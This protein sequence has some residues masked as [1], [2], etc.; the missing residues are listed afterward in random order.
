MERITSEGWMHSMRVFK[1]GFA[2]VLIFVILLTLLYPALQRVMAAEFILEPSKLSGG[3]Y[4]NSDALAAMLDQVFAGDIDIYS[5]NRYTQEVTM[6]VGVYM[7]NNAL[8]YVKSQTTGNP[9]S[10]W[11]CYIYGNAV[12]NKL[13]REWVGHAT[14]FMHSRVV[15]SGGSNTLSYEMM[16][17]AGVL[18]GAYLRTTGNS[19]GSY[20]GSVGHSM[21][22]LAYDPDNITYLEGNGDGNGLVRVAIRSWEDFNQ[23]QL[24]G[25]GRYIAHMVQPADEF[26]QQ[27]Y[28]S[29]P[30]DGYEG[31]G[32]CIDCGSV[33]DWQSTEDPWAKGI[34]RLTEKVTPRSDAPY[35][36]ATAADVILTKGQT[37]QTTGQYRNAFDQIWYRAQDDAGNTFYVNG[38][39]L[40][41]VEYPSLEVSC[42]DFSPEDGAQLEQK[43]Y[44]VKGT[45]TANFPLKSVSGYLDGQLYAT[46]TATDE[47]T[48]VVDLRKTDLNHNLSFSKLA[49]GK[50][51]VKV[52]VR[53]FVHGWDMTVHESAF[54]TLSAEPCSHDYVGT[55]TRDATCTEDGLLTYTCTKC[56]DAYT[57]TIAA[58]GHDYQNYVCVYCA[59]EMVLSGLSGN[60]QSAGKPEVP[61]RITLS[62]D[63]KEVYS[64]ES[65]AGSY[66]LTGILPGT[67]VITF[68]KTDCVPL[69]TELTLTPGDTS[70]DAK[71]CIPGDVNGD[72]SLNI[73]DMGRIYAHIRGTNQFQ[74]AYVLLCADYNGD[75]TLNIGDAVKLYGFLRRT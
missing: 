21:I 27:H 69:S 25:R 52:V 59:D 33:Y 37:I 5:D 7:D 2:I 20:N 15:I 75:G 9:V 44:P 14:G 16:E 10:G 12:Y 61:V 43:A 55:V 23:R 34:Y 19:D 51:T 46:W 70:L 50:H 29:C 3:D 11:Q 26:Y 6:P 67:Y 53:S 64:M 35:H 30:H 41:F 39:S 13:F 40:K 72:N 17:S 24:S 47:V 45:I 48:N 4:T 31:C 28:P 65:A 62:Q 57:R 42:T 58:H 8:Y 73:G 38:A 22:I 54:Y 66:T 68:A 74:D 1:K 49:G 18:C 63:G 60:I 71:L 36:A 56:P 32:V